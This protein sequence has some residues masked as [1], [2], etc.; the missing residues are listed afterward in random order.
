MVLIDALFIN[1]GG[2][3]VL[4]K[5]LIECILATPQKDNFFFV[6]DPRF[7]KPD[8]LHKNYIVINNKIR[9][10]IK[11][12]R[13]HKGKFSAVFCFAN[14]PPPVKLKVPVYTYF[15]NQKLLAAP[16]QRFRRKHFSQYLK[17]L[18]VKFYNKNTDYYIVQTRH[19]VEALT[20]LGLKDHTHCL[21]IPFYDD[22]KYLTGHKPFN[23]RE[24]DAFVFISNPSPQKNHLTLLDA[25]EYLLEKKQTPILHVTI[26][27]TAP[28][29][30]NRMHE[31]N[32]KGTRIVNH[33]YLDPRELYFS[34]PYLIFP[35]VIESF[36]LPLIEAVDSGMKVIA[37]DLPYVH[38]VIKPSLTFQP[39]D[40]ISIAAAV[41]KALETEL[42]FPELLIRNEVDKLIELLIS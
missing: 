42:P 24:K 26:D 28:H 9:D 35:S 29:L 41:L 5:Y 27:H 15:Q 6:L 10:R 20:A 36:G 39:L 2:G 22:R 33:V 21:T 1:K 25:W 8:E 16:G 19:M 4:L 32:A 18:A 3:A 7:H 38:D 17:F 34:C 40:K 23:E 12:Y 11:F 30:I 14:T 13:A 37:S 31:L